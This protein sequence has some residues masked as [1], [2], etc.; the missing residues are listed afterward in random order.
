MFEL[1]RETVAASNPSGII[2]FCDFDEGSTQLVLIIVPK[3]LC[4]IKQTPWQFQEGPL[5]NHSCSRHLGD[6]RGQA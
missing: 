4:V 2:D 1:T 3:K 5:L 6:Y